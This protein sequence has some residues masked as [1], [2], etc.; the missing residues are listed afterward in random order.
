MTNTEPVLCYVALGSNLGDSDKHI[1]DG[2]Q[3]LAN[4]SDID[5]INTSL[6]YQSKPHGPQDQPDY[7][8]AAVEFK[9]TLT[10][11]NLLD[12]LQKIENKNGRVREGV[13]R[14]GARTLD[15]DLLFYGDETI[16]TKRLI[17]P[18]PRICER[19]F[20]LY[21]LRDLLSVTTAEQTKEDQEDLKINDK[22]TLSNCIAKLSEKDKSEIKEYSHH[23]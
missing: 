23:G 5:F 17:V 4:H 20:V 13:E 9:T 2:L 1:M 21:P 10:P 15:L 8:N 19:A 22:S 18:H 14:W 6:L 7:I 16:N 12:E 11:E 3:A